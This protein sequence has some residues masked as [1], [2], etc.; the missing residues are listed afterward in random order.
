[1]AYITQELY[2][3]VYK[4]LFAITGAGTF[5]LNLINKICELLMAS[6]THLPYEFQW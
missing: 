5:I 1:M 3:Y 2:E 4:K 6:S